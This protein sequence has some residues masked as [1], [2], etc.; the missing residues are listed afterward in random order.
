M[1]NAI[2]NDDSFTDV[3]DRVG[4]MM[5]Q[6]IG[7]DNDNTHVA[8]APGDENESS[9]RIASILTFSTQ[10]AILDA[11]DPK[12]KEEPL[13]AQ[14]APAHLHEVISTEVCEEYVPLESS[15]DRRK[16]IGIVTLY[17][18]TVAILFADMNLLAPN[19]SIV[20]EEF[21]MDD[22]ERDIKLGGLIALG[23]FF[24]GAPVSFVVGWLADSMNRSPLF[25]ATVFVGELGCFMVFFV[26]S[27][28][29]L[30]VCR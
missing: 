8:V 6:S 9:S 7:E 5:H 3:S 13:D 25:A 10:E 16:R 15:A 28:W 22:D 11:D 4:T 27:Y 30:Y 26:Q 18:I 29:Q 24:V 23:F 21:G 1:M 19:L 20:A 17:L 12:R 2:N 14:N